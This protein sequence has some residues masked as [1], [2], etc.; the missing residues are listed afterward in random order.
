[1]PTLLAVPRLRLVTDVSPGDWVAKG[2]GP[3]GSGVGSLLPGGFEAYVRILHPAV[4]RDGMPVRWD[5]VATWSGATAHPRAQ[6][7]AIARPR[8]GA[9]RQLAPFDQRP[10]VGRLPE[11][12]LAALCDV[13][14]TH[15][16][17]PDRCWFCV[18]DGYGWISGPTPLSVLGDAPPFPPAFGLAAQSSPR[19]RLPERAYLLFDGPLGAASDVGWWLNGDL[20]IPQS[21]NLFWPDDRAWCVATEIDLDSTF[22]GG[23]AA[24]TAAVLKDVRFEAWPSELTDPVSASSDEINH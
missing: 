20:V 6:F 4:S 11:P 16:R 10:P 18:W 9:D 5:S 22:V 2:V 24:L 14:T 23:S 21:P 7:E 12:L 19:V 8:R 3:L 15:T 17:M 1:V 13:L